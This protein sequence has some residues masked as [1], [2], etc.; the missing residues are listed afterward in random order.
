MQTMRS[1][2]AGHGILALIMQ[3]ERYSETILMAANEL[4]HPNL[5]KGNAL[6]IQFI[7]YCWINGCEERG[8][9]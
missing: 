5:P 2:G 4:R 1:G 8:A 7:G 6:W 9:R 3:S